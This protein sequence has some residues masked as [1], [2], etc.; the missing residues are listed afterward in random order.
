MRRGGGFTL[1]ELLV[2]IA[3]I[4]ILAAL[5]MPA[6]EKARGAARGTLCT[7]NQ[8]Q[9]GIAVAMYLGANSDRFPPCGTYWYNRFCAAAGW[10]APWGYWWTGAFC[11]TC[12][13]PPWCPSWMDFTAPYFGS[14]EV[15]Q[16]SEWKWHKLGGCQWSDDRYLYGYGVNSN[17]MMYWDFNGGDGSIP[18]RPW[19]PKFTSSMVRNSGRVVLIFDRFRSDRMDVPR[20]ANCVIGGVAF[21]H[22]CGQPRPPDNNAAWF[23][24][25]PVLS[26]SVNTLF[27]D[28]HAGSFSSVTAFEAAIVP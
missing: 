19:I 6:L 1:I 7:S 21:R 17:V 28:G 5:L 14:K 11:D 12:A 24:P 22:P 16:C 2:V 3:I 18:G 13:G 15:L 4:A 8:K 25:P 20:F 27:V 10:P 26:G 23:V 9:L